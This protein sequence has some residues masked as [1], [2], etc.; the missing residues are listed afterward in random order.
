VTCFLKRRTVSNQTK[1]IIRDLG[2]GLVLRHGSPEDGEALA[3]FNG[4]YLGDDGPA[5]GMTME[6]V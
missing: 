6:R 2:N 5:G 3:L 4:E 1:K